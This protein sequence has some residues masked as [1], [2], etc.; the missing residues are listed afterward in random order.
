VDSASPIVWGLLLVG[1]LVVVNAFFVAAEYALVRVRRTQ[2]EAL[3]AQGSGLA[4]VV[5]HGLNHLSRYIAG[6]QVGITLAGLA[7]GRFGEPVLT[8]LLY[9]LLA[10]LLPPSLLGPEV[11][12][13]LATGLALLVISYLL[14]VL[15]ELVPK[16]IAL[17]YTEQV[18]LLIAKPMRLAVVVF[19]PLIWSMNALGNAILRLL[20]L[21]PEENGHG[22]HSVEELRLLIVQSH[23]AGI[24]EDIERQ[25]MQRS[26]QFADLCV[27]DVMIPRMDIVALDLSLPAEA[28]LDQ[29]ARTIHTRLPAY[30][31]TLDNVVG[32]LHLQDLFKHVRQSPG[33]GSLRQ[34]VRPALFVPELIPLNDLLRTFQ[35]RQTQI[36]LVVNEHGGVDGL[37]T[38][39][40]IVEELVG[41]VHDALEAVQP[42]IQDTP[43]G[44]VLVRGEVRLR[45]LNERLGWTL[46]DEDVDTIAGYIMKGLGRAAHVGD[47]IPTPYG[48]IRVENM[49]H[50]RIT[51]VAIIPAPT[52]VPEAQAED[53]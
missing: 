47:V 1:V 41:E 12:T 21:P 30:E 34:L 33:A 51:Q 8:A 7:S 42:S 24:L 35:Q 3:A 48:T 23:Q 20:H 28:V 38:L 40:D 5:L 27:A 15:S 46:Q 36:A 11:S 19:T 39:E 43:D 29:A 37:V 13:A 4:T 25:L 18:A 32:I 14:V 22:A 31:D 50:V 26:V 45:E 52:T 53:A 9:P 16:A 17:Q 44:R 49:A 6:V 10:W 2:M